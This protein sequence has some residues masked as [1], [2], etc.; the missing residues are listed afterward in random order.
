MKQKIQ[1][2]TLHHENFGEIKVLKNYYL[3][4]DERIQTKNAE[5]VIKVLWDLGFRRLK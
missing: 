1:Q 4:G 3:A 2:I 5:L